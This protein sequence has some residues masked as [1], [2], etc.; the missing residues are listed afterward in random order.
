MRHRHGRLAWLRLDKWNARPPFARRTRQGRLQ[1][2]RRQRRLRE[3]T[4]H[5]RRKTEVVGLTNEQAA[6][7]VVVS[8]RPTRASALSSENATLFVRPL[9]PGGH[10]EGISSKQRNGC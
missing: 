8:G 1:Y 5:V 3:M 9:K 4:R 6:T 10:V 7:L 2:H